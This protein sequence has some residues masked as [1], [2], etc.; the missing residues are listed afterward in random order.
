MST[1]T[2][3]EAKSRPILFKC[4]MVQAI[5][6]GQKTIT[7]RVMKP[8]PPAWIESFGYSAF[9]PDG[10]ISGRGNYEDWG[11][12]EKFFRCPY[13]RPGN[14]LWVRETWAK[15]E[16]INADTERDRAIHYLHH[17]ASYDGDLGNEWHYYGRWRPSIHMPRWASRITLRVTA[18]RVERLRDITLAD[19]K[20]EGI[21]E[22]GSEY[23]QDMTEAE[24]DEWRNRSTLENFALLWDQINGKRPGCS[25]ADS[26]WVW[27]ISFERVTP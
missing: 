20:S 9:T 15:R 5:L 13:G 24:L 22:Y 12:S 2:T 10:H 17:R 21:P 6:A 16:D 19:A 3:Q 8:Q 11:P 7:R 27:V 1:M 23:R 18:V 4:P 14:M 26:P 25:W